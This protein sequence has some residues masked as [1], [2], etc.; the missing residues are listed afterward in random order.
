MEQRRLRLL[1]R[2]NGQAAVQ[3]E[4]G[5][6]EEARETVHAAVNHVVSKYC[7]TSQEPVQ[8]QQQQYAYS[9]TTLML[10]WQAR[11][12]IL[13]LRKIGLRYETLGKQRDD[14]VLVAIGEKLVIRSVQL[15][16]INPISSSPP[17]KQRLVPKRKLIDQYSSCRV[18][19]AQT[20]ENGLCGS[21]DGC[22]SGL[23]RRHESRARHPL[24][25][26]LAARPATSHDV[27]HDP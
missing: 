20:E 22:L 15:L 1:K 27:V 4:S 16:R 12:S 3:L 7:A 19:N 5:R 10:Q 25:L 2:L 8:V 23:I 14:K 26:Q 9:T 17:M 13:L 18:A 21:L 6:L 11:V 24:V